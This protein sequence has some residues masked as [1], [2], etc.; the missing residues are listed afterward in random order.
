VLA[1]GD[2]LL[3]GGA[4]FQLRFQDSVVNSDMKTLQSLSAN[5]YTPDVWAEMRYGKLRLEVEAAWVLG[6]MRS[7][8][9][10][11]EQ[12]VSQFGAA[13]EGELRLMGEKLGIYL[14]SGIATGDAQTEGLSS[15][16]NYFDF[17]GAK[18]GD[19]MANNHLVSTFRFHPAYRVDMI[20][21]RSILGQVTGA[22]YIKPGISYDFVRDAF[23]QLFGARIDAIYSRATSTIQTWGNDANLGVELNGQIY[24]H[25]A[26]GPDKND[27]YHAALQYG[28]LFPMDGLGYYYKSVNLH[29]AQT[30]RLVLGVVF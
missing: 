24:W 3:N 25:S 12:H 26:D 16:A 8:T 15:D 23:G 13:F 7:L 9:N 1:R 17:S 28:V 14:Y 19:P 29:T 22:W 10:G 30:L 20:L 2:V 5:L 27:G 11:N 4:R 6:H 18:A 21:W